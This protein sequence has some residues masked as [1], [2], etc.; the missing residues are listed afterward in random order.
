LEYYDTQ[1]A[2]NIQK[3]DSDRLQRAVPSM[4]NPWLETR[5]EERDALNSVVMSGE[6]GFDVV[7][8][9]LERLESEDPDD[10]VDIVNATSMISHGVDVD[11]LNFISFFGMPTNGGVHP[12]VL[13][14]RVVTSRVPSST[15]ST[16]STS[17]TAH[18]TRGS[19]GTTTSRPPCRS[20]PLERWAEFAV[21]CTMPGIFAATLL[22]YYDEQLESSV[23]R[24][25]LY[26]SFREAQRAGDID[27]DELLEFVKR[28]YCV[29]PGQRPE[30][31]EDRTVDLYERKVEREFED[32]SG[33]DVCPDTRRTATRDGSVT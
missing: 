33:N 17:A 9:V 11:T 31:A 4:I 18:T 30:W 25:Y 16:R 20:D 26:D 5:D 1:V 15:C 2:Y 3:V 22:Q 21:S 32:T 12:G 27:K 6:T 10:P 29:T 23:G 24:V 7:R 19:T 8:D 14:C 28:S 13:P